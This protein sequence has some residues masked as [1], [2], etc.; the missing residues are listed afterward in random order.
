MIIRSWKQ[1]KLTVLAVLIALQAMLALGVERADAAGFRWQV[2]GE[3]TRSGPGGFGG[4]EDY[5][6]ELLAQGNSLFVSYGTFPTVKRWDGSGWHGV[7]EPKFVIAPTSKTSFQGAPDG[8]LYF[9]YWDQIN[10]QRPKAMTYEAGENWTTLGGAEAAAVRSDWPSIAVDSAKNVYMSYLN[11]DD[12]NKMYVSKIPDGGNGWSV[13]GGPVSEGA[14]WFGDISIGADNRPYVV[15]A[16]AA[17]NYLPSVRFYNGTAWEYVGGNR[18]IAEVSSNLPQIVAAQNGKLYVVYLSGNEIA[19]KVYVEQFDGTSWNT[20]GSWNADESNRPALALDINSNPYLA[21][22]DADNGDKVTVRYYD[23]DTWDTI[24]PTGFSSG[25][26]NGLSI[27]VDADDSLY[28]AYNDMDDGNKLK[29]MGYLWDEIEP[30]VQSFSP[31]IGATNAAHNASLTMTFTEEVAVDGTDVA[32]LYRTASDMLVESFDAADA[33][34]NGRSV[35]FQP[36]EPLEDGVS[37]YVVVEADGIQDLAGNGFAGLQ[38]TDWYFTVEDTLDPA[39]ESLNPANGSSGASVHVKPSLTFSESVT[40]EFGKTIVIRN[41]S[42][43]SVVESFDTSSSTRLKAQ[44]KTIVIEP[45]EPLAYETEYQIDI[46]EGTIRDWSGK[47]FGAIVGTQWRFTTGAEPDTRQPSVSEVAPANGATSVPVDSALT[48]KF[49]EPVKAGIGNILIVNR[50]ALEIVDTIS[51]LETSKVSFNAD[52]VT[53]QPSRSLDFGTKYGISVMPGVITDLAGNAFAGIMPMGWTFT[54]VLPDTVAPTLTASSPTN[55]QANVA[56][57]APLRIAFDE[58]VTAVAGKEIFITDA[59]TGNRFATIYANNIEAVTVAGSDVTIKPFDDFEFGKTYYVEIEDGAFVDAAGNPYAGLTGISE[60]RFTIGAA[61]DVV[62]PSAISLSPADGTV[63]V[64]LNSELAVTFNEPVQ[65]AAG[66][67]ITLVKVAGAQPVESFPATDTAKVTVN[68][69]TVRIHPSSPLAYS[70]E[71][72]LL[73]S[74]GAFQDLAGNGI[75][76]LNAMG[77]WTFTTKIRPAPIGGGGG[78]SSEQTLFGQVKSDGTDGVMAEFVVR[79]TADPS[80]RFLDSAT[81]TTDWIQSVLK[82]LEDKGVK[83]VTLSWPTNNGGADLADLKMSKEAVQALAIAGVALNLETKFVQAAISNETFQGSAKEV[84]FHMESLQDSAARDAL[85]KRA[86]ASNGAVALFGTPVKMETTAQGHSIEFTLPIGADETKKASG[87]EM[88]IYLEYNDGT[89]ELVSGKLGSQGVKF[90]ASKP[91]TFALVQVK[92]WKEEAKPQPKAPSMAYMNGFDNGTFRPE[93]E[94]TRAEI[95]TIVS[96]VVQR[97]IVR[98]SVAFADMTSPYWAGPAI[99]KAVSMGVM[100]GSPDGKFY[101]D[102][103]ITRG[104]IAVIVAQ[105]IEGDIGMGTTFKDTNGHWAQKAI[106]TVSA[107]RIMKGFTDGTF[108]PGQPLHRA[109]AVVIINRLLGIAPAVRSE[110]RWSDVPAS[111]WAFGDIQAASK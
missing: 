27:A 19:A 55:G 22:S 43:Q 14:A 93:A 41:V 9:G 67:T 13:E 31:A 73:F 85:V 69:A 35:T 95:A 16:D 24:G 3:E 79:R 86:S 91:G 44:G 72:A 77:D 49:D 101:P 110:P 42:D 21:Y 61:P 68:G 36:S 105:L 60:W 45:S 23:G 62:G 37:Y 88:G 90:S 52:T 74:A 38:R 111:H 63:G 75:T 57:N 109:E 94:L 17:N 97:P 15:Y 59:D 11:V 53:I 48:M 103:T 65:P 4:F 30:T 5:E 20:I 32:G 76:G 39:L 56:A 71:Y 58:N 87:E 64:E 66:G 47:L 28:I 104:E 80:G 2:I 102:K 7:G 100:R 8:T 82:K 83:R 107:A 18:S 84:S 106:D 70:T 54:T 51:I 6:P 26:P 33:T 40:L 108:R 1:A 12:G 89:T 99:D 50:D 10:N 92:G 78:G 29:V 81:F 96:R 98:E 25:R 34:V 46:P